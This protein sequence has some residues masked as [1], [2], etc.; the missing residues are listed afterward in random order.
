MFYLQL[1]ELIKDNA[2]ELSRRLCKD[3]LSMEETKGYRRFSYEVTYDRVFDVF[4]RLSSWLGMDDHTASEIRKVYT[5]LGRKRFREDLPLH[6]VV[7]A[8]MLIKRH[9]WFFIQENQFFETTYEFKQ[10]LELNN[11]VVLFFDR[12]IYF[13][14]MGYEEELLKSKL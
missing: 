9:L 6:E 2:N 4:S 14:T 10:A 3:L 1:L 12:V 13:V 7:L 5:E 11:K 8:F